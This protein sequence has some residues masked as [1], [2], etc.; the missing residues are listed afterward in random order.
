MTAATTRKLIRILILLISFQCISA[1]FFTVQGSGNEVHAAALHSKHQK[2]FS[3]IFEKAAEEER[4]EEEGDKFLAIELV[5]FSKLA[6]LRSL[7]Y[8]PH[9]NSTPYEQRIAPQHQLFMLHCVF[10]I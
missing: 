10:I 6:T 3:M 2:S 7:G 1:A 8:T 4:S 5:D 9:I